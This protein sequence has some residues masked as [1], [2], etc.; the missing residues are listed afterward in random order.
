MG[1]GR[2]D[3]KLNKTEKSFPNDFCRICLTTLSEQNVSRKDWTDGRDEIRLDAEGYAWCEDCT[4]EYDRRYKIKNREIKFRAWDEE[5]KNMIEWH[6]EFF[7]D[8][9]PVTR[10]SRSFDKLDYPIMQYTGLKD[11][12]GAEIYE[13]DIIQTTDIDNTVCRTVVN[14][15]QGAYW[16]GFWQN[17]QPKVIEETNSGG[18]WDEVELE[19]PDGEL[20]YFVLQ[21]NLDFKVIGNVYEN[22][23]LIRD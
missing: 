9:S 8:T 19:V 3:S 4:K 11:S 1:V 2:G 10:Y 15:D 22:P 7:Y 16:I 20:L 13:G 12:N 6:D 5:N 14:F 17:C 23:E 18:Y 21:Y